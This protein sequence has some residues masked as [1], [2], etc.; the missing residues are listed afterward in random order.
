MILGRRGSCIKEQFTRYHGCSVVKKIHG[1]SLCGNPHK[2][3]RPQ[4]TR[5]GDTVSSKQ[6]T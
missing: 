4:M 6:F 2:T 3:D 1:Y 5:P